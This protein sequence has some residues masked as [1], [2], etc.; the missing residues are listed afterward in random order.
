MVIV[1]KKEENCEER[2]LTLTNVNSTHFHE[3]PAREDESLANLV[4][5]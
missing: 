4:L 3:N 2:M 5:S 1:L